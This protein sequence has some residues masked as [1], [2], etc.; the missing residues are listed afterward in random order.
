MM[1]RMIGAFAATVLAATVLGATA[2]AAEPRPEGFWLTE[3]GR[4]IVA[5]QPCRGEGLCG[6]MVWVANPLDADGAVKL[7]AKGQPLCGL[8]LAG[9]LRDDGDGLWADGWIYNPRSGDT[10]GA[11]IEPLSETELKVRGYVLLPLFGSSQIWTRVDGD[12]GGC[13]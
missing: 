10:Y 9:A 8:Q 5:I 12:R 13:G 7:D 3:N 6:Q 1:F 4:G 2:H 11:E